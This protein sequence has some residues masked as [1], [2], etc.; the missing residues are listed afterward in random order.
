MSLRVDP[1]CTLR[2]LALRAA[3]LAGRPIRELERSFDAEASGPM[4]RRKGKTGQL[5]EQ[6]LGAY[7]GSARGPDFERLGVELKTLPLDARGRPSESTFVCSLALREVDM[8]DWSSSDVRRKLAHVLFVP[9]EQAHDAD[10]KVGRPF[11]FRPTSEQESI[12]RADFD[13]LLGMIALGRIEDVTARLGTWLQIR[14]KAAHGRVRTVAYGCDDEPLSTI[15]RGFY[16]RARFTSL[17]LSERTGC[18]V[19]DPQPTKDSSG[20]R[21]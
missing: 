1:P 21:R 13:D 11:F 9:I 20:W 7:A 19:V 2:E 3:A 8:A 4:L 18:E 16:L 10:R 12:L 17:L 14:P 6:A 15:P 5:I